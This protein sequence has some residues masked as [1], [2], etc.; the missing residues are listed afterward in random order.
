MSAPT[1][2]PKEREANSCLSNST[3]LSQA[4]AIGLQLPSFL[5]SAWA[6]ALGAEEQRRF[7]GR[8]SNWPDVSFDS[9]P[10]NPT[11]NADL[12]CVDLVLLRHRVTRVKVL[13]TAQGASLSQ[14]WFITVPI[15]YNISWWSADLLPET[16]PEHPALSP[17]F[18]GSLQS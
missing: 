9:L 10:L 2:H 17:G 11:A 16:P 3:G 15:V 6:D 12:L 7:R 18:H 14:N 1:Q 4:E 13:T 8:G 5:C